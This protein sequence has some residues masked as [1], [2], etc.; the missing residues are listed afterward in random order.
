MRNSN[1][2]YGN[3]FDAKVMNSMSYIDALHYKNTCAQTLTRELVKSEA[4]ST[5]WHRLNTVA[6]A[7]KFNQELIKE[8]EGRD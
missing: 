5:D 6:K 1:F 4:M 7:I 2:I 8:A 3:N